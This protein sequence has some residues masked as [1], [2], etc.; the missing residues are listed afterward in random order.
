MGRVEH[1]QGLST[2]MMFAMVGATLSPENRAKPV[3]IYDV[4]VLEW[5]A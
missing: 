1:A 4:V 5:A 3:A 2:P